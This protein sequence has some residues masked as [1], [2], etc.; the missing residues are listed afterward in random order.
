MIFIES[1][2]DNVN[3]KLVN[4]KHD[5]VTSRETHKD[6]TKNNNT[7]EVHFYSVYNTKQ[8]CMITHVFC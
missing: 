1:V 2:P 6:E 5:S 3:T 7:E 8:A 4:S